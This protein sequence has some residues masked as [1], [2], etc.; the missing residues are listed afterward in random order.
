MGVVMMATSLPMIKLLLGISLFTF[1]YFCLCSHIPESSKKLAI[2]LPHFLWDELQEIQEWS[3]MGLPFP[4]PCESFSRHN[5]RIDL[6][7]NEC[8]NVYYLLLLTMGCGESGL[9]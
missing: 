1:E 7:F 2:A 8:D 5:H 6:G 9:L 4:D 3:N